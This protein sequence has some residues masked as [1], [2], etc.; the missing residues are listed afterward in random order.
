M[1][2]DDSDKVMPQ[3]PRAYLVQTWVVEGVKGQGVAVRVRGD[4]GSSPP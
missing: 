4:V 2:T 1:G 3:S